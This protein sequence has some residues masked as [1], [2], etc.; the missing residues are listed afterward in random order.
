MLPGMIFIVTAALVVFLICFLV[1]GV[2]DIL[3]S[4]PDSWAFVYISRVPAHRCSFDMNFP[5]HFG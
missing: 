4:C 2:L 1:V 3:D 5:S